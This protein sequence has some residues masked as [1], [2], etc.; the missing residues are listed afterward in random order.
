M[1]VKGHGTFPHWPISHYGNSYMATK[2][3]VGY[4]PSFATSISSHFQY[5]EGKLIRTLSMIVV[6]AVRR[7]LNIIITQ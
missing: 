2:V 7:F 5:L 3:H 6:E 4:L 1:I